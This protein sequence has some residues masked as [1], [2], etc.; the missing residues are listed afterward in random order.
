VSET[1]G[2]LIF[3]ALFAIAIAIGNLTSELRRGRLQKW[4]LRELLQ[5]LHQMTAILAQIRDSQRDEK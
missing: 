5:P 1:I 3:L 4:E 2:L